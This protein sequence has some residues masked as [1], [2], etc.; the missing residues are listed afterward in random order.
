M[1]PPNSLFS[2]FWQAHWLVNRYDRADD[3]FGW[4]GDRIDKTF[5]FRRM[6]KGM[7]RFEQAFWSAS[8]WKSFTNRY[9]RSRRIRWRRCSWPRCEWKAASGQARRSQVVDAHEKVM[10][11]TIARGGTAERRLLCRDRRFR[12]SLYRPFRHGLGHY[13]ELPVDRGVKNTCS[14]WWRRASRG[15]FATAIARGCHT[16][17]DF[18]IKFASEVNKQAQRLEGL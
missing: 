9:R 14:R 10:D 7:D 2:L 6:R 16:G 18:H 8:R 1:S 17:D 5:L 11:V 13:D 15:L 12:L 3:L 4:S